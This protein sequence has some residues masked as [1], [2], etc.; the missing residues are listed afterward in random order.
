MPNTKPQ[1]KLGHRVQDPTITHGVQ[2]D[3]RQRLNAN[4]ATEDWELLKSVSLNRGTCQTVTANLIHTFCNI[5]RKHGVSTRIDLDKFHVILAFWSG[6]DVSPEA[7]VAS[8]ATSYL[9]FLPEA[10][11]RC[12]RDE[13]LRDASARTG[14]TESS[15][16]DRGRQKAVRGNDP[17]AKKV[18]SGVQRKGKV[19]QRQ[20]GSGARGTA[21][22]SDQAQVAGDKA[23][24]GQGAEA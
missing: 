15:G 9:S 12:V 19:G 8:G 3:D 21:G 20:A 5:L 6:L 14:G 1:F 11:A 2:N 7:V 23:E 22:G 10:T 16:D 24:G 17:R 4:L 18:T 13:V